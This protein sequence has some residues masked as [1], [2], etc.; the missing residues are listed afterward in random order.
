MIA[1]LIDNS[2]EG[3]QTSKQQRAIFA[4]FACPEIFDAK[5]LREEETVEL[6]RQVRWLNFDFEKPQAQNYGTAL[7]DCRN[8][9]TVQEAHRAT[10]LWE[11]LVGI[12]DEKR[13]LGGMLDLPALLKELKG[14]FTFKDNP[15]FAGDWI[16]L[17]KRSAAEMIE[18]KTEIAGLPRLARERELKAIQADVD[19][20]S[21]CFLVGD[22]GCGKS[23]LA[24]T[25]AAANYKRI[26]WLGNDSLEYASLPDFGKGIGLRHSITDIIDSTVENTILVFDAI[27][28]FS[29]KAKKVAVQLIRA[30]HASVSAE[31]TSIILTAQAEGAQS[32][33]VDLLSL[34]VP[35]C[36]LKTRTVVRPAEDDVRAIVVG[37]PKVG[38]VA[39]RSEMKTL[40]TN[41]KMLDWFIQFSQSGGT[42]STSNVGLT[43]LIDSLW[44][45]WVETGDD[46][47]AKSDLLIKIASIEADNHV[48]SVSRSSLAHVEQET[49]GKVANGELLRVQNNRIRFSHDLLSDWARLQALIDGD[50][51]ATPQ[52][53]ERYT[54]PRWSRAI[55]LYGQRLLEQSPD[56][57]E[58]WQKSLEAVDDGTATGT[59]VRDL[60]LE[61][62]FVAP[63]STIL[64]EQSWPALSANNGNLLN[65][66]I[67][68]FL[69]VATLPDP[70]LG[71]MLDDPHDAPK[72][73]HLMRLPYL[74]YWGPLIMVLH[75]HREEV[76]RLAPINASRVSALWLRVMNLGDSKV[77]WRQEAAELAF[78]SAREVQFLDEIGPHYSGGS[79]KV[80]FEA[81]LYA[82]TELPTEVG[83][84][85]LELAKRRDLGPEVIKRVAEARAKRREEKKKRAVSSLT[86]KSPPPTIS[87][88]GP[89]RKP[90]PDG[91]RSRVN[92][93]FRNACLE[94]TAFGSFATANPDVALEVLLAVCI[95]EPQHEEFGQS[96]GEELGLDYWQSGEPSMWFRGPFLRFL[97]AAPAQGLTFILKL[98]N[99][100]TLRYSRSRGI[101][102]KISRK[103]R[104]WLGDSNAFVWH[105]DG[106]TM[107]G[108]ILHC[109]LMALEKW[110]YDQL[111]T[112]VEITPALTRIM[113]ESESLAFAGLLLTVGK[114][115]PSLLVGPLRPLL[116]PWLLWSW[117][118]QLTEQRASGSRGSF[119][120]WG[121]QP[122]AAVTLAKAWI[123][124]PHRLKTMRDLMVV[125]FLP[126]K[127][128]EEFFEKLVMA[129]ERQL[130][131]D[132]QP[133][134][135][136]CLVE[137][138]RKQ[139]YKFGTVDGVLVPTE[140]SWPESDQIEFDTEAQRASEDLQLLRLPMQCRKILDAG[141]CYKPETL[142][143]FFEFIKLTS[144]K[145]VENQEDGDE[146]VHPVEDGVF[147]GIAVLTVLHN[148]WLSSDTSRMAW[149]R[150]QLEASLT[151]PPPRSRYFS[152]ISNGGET[153]DAFATECGI[154]MLARDPSDGLA[155][156]LVSRGIV[157]FFYSTTQLVVNKAAAL[158]ID[159][160]DDFE[161]IV[162][163]A[164]R[165]SAIR[166]AIKI[167]PPNFA[168]EITQW[169]E[170]KTE[171][172]T[173]F[174]DGSLSPALPDIKH[175]NAATRV[176]LDEIH[177]KQYPEH[178]AFS[179]ARMGRKGVRQSREALHPQ[180][181]GLDTRVV[182]AALSWLT[183]RSASTP[184]ERADII[185][186]LVK[187]LHLVLST[188]PIVEDRETQELKG[189][190]SD[191]DSWVFELL[192]DAIPQLDPSEKPELLWQPILDLG[193]H[194][195][196]WVERFYWSWFTRGPQAK[197]N[198]NNF[199]RQWR[200]MIQFAFDNEKW[201]RKASWHYQLD[202]MIF[203]LLGFDGRWS[204]WKSTEDIVPHIDA[205]VD[206]YE[207]AAAKWF[208][209]PKVLGGFVRFAESL[210]G[211][212]LALK[213]IPWVAA[214]IKDY[215]SYDW[216]HGIEEAVI[217]FLDTCWQCHA[218]RITG[219]TSIR[220]DFF[221]ILTALTARGSHAAIALRDRVAN[222]VQG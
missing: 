193:A 13:K 3:Q 104:R 8:V 30:V 100:A 180:R 55:R 144:G 52:S 166:P 138:I 1:R 188:I 5:H 157:S 16:E 73:E 74:P 117:D 194:P 111:E 2:Q 220:A 101:T 57:G 92:Q 72:Y 69:Y 63:N 46:K 146:P 125:R 64:L 171:L 165:W 19:E 134:K 130:D 183:L 114:M 120:F 215:D 66:L 39:L 84:L 34:G 119:G 99:F 49:L 37:L 42:I 148:E 4:S 11:R 214:A 18:I 185:L 81:L 47:F 115:E 70:R 14:Q 28:G 26:I 135:L 106:H 168:A 187:V 62:L 124:L 59:L 24:K 98:V 60:F 182:T 201:D 88:L 87:L 170:R 90:W 169:E 191:F 181:L 221:S 40:L 12:A 51:L 41:L 175:L 85:C 127:E 156:A 33:L 91:P 151:T 197:P 218:K 198:L 79:D 184:A 195:H 95:E 152:E 36:V 89:L 7:S 200:A 10:E 154:S 21:S 112:K 109:A 179:R 160:N 213:S 22:S 149:C 67:D 210:P 118:F 150:T 219:D 38:W 204:M 129:W 123:D 172:V 132:R 61:A 145:E 211:S 186:W 137:A 207:R 196:E 31:R 140:F 80:V 143:G 96:P 155:R 177:A 58:S 158:K 121:N 199:F 110:L 167:L 136:R 133:I 206:L 107:H 103:H 93:D 205:M 65:I 56:G 142:E 173:S 126:L 203:E 163:A 32:L 122:K 15:E 35:D 17:A 20:R 9:L 45:H 192:A 94:G 71:L 159:L 53:R 176:A 161:R 162:V 25:F 202:S 82:A 141:T 217:D 116:E 50:W 75:A 105:Y 54:S 97:N 131:E 44:S 208:D 83:Q 113:N 86:H 48:N 209:M 27:E 190:P 43:N 23:A 139:N 128:H 164:L 174:N 216:R 6:V 78:V 178:A 147:G 153:W 77:V 102:F 108:T 68:R 222:D 212:S 29:R 189:L 76:V